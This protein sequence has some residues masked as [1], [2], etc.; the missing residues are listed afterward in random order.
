MVHVARAGLARL[1]RVPLERVDEIAKELA[2]LHRA[3][4]EEVDGLLSASALIQAPLLYIVVRA[5]APEVAV[6]TGVSSGYSTR[7]MLAAIERNGHGRLHSIGTETIAL[8]GGVP[9]DDP[10]AGRP[11]GWLVPRPLRARWTLHVGRS[12]AELP[13]LWE[14]ESPAVDLFLHDSLHS[15]ETMLWEYT[16]AWPHLVRGGVLLSHDVQVNRAWPTFLAQRGLTGDEQLDHD[17]GAVRV[18]G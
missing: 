1:L 17:L 3:L 13:K 16:Q 6:E 2:P 11:V 10:L 15:Y 5:L 14:K 9:D 7:L 8:K 4:T 12:E 18:P